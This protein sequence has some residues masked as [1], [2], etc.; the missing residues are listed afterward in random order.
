MKNYIYNNIKGVLGAFAVISLT[1]GMTC[2]SQGTDEDLI[3]SQKNERLRSICP[4]GY[5]F[6][7][8]QYMTTGR[9]DSMMVILDRP[10]YAWR[11]SCVV[12]VNQ[13]QTDLNYLLGVIDYN[14]TAQSDTLLNGRYNMLSFV[15]DTKSFD[16]SE[17]NSFMNRTSE[18]GIFELPLKYNGGYDGIV[19]DPKRIFS[20]YMRNFN[21]YDPHHEEYIPMDPNCL[22]Q[23]Y[24][25][26]FV[27]HKTDDVACIDAVTVLVDGIP[28]SVD[29]TTGI[30]DASKLVQIR[31]VGELSHPDDFVSGND[32]VTVQIDAPA[33]LYPSHENAIKTIGQFGYLHAYVTLRNQNG[34]SKTHHVRHKM[35][36]LNTSESYTLC[37]DSAHLKVNGGSSYQNKITDEILVNKDTVNARN[38]SLWTVVK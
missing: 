2:C 15:Y 36:E 12:K 33:V 37:E 38:Y 24:T 4:K 17:I 31:T 16:Y 14:N 30:V 20:A 23:H 29:L 6:Y 35:N 19:T 11:S 3:S 22:T 1:M 25:W 21:I 10:I 13:S 28:H 34:I 32:T 5:T 18:Y 9:P 7:V 8:S 26:K 27:I